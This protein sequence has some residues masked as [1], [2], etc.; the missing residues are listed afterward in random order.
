MTNNDVTFRLKFS[1]D[2]VGFTSDDINVS[3]G[4]KGV[5][6]GSG[7]NYTLIVRPDQGVI[8]K[9][10]VEVNSETFIDLSGNSN[11]LQSKASQNFDTVGGPIAKDYLTNFIAQEDDVI[12]GLNFGEIY[13]ELVK[14]K[15]YPDGT[16][17]AESFTIKSVSI[18]G[19]DALRPSVGGVT[20]DE[21]GF[22]QIDTRV[23]AYQH[24]NTDEVVDVV[25]KFVVTDNV[26][27]TDIGT[28]KFQVAGLDDVNIIEF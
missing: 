15:H 8:G 9:I 3:G 24:L 7:D 17:T 27:L 4:R 13:S 10:T 5:F 1:E 21:K 18:D 26:G 22:V 23:E 25:A 14:A 2:V 16:F 20:V 19:G 28:V 12:R 6:S 11:I